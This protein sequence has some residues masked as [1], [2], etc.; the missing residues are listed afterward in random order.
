MPNTCENIR[1]EL[2]R[3]NVVLPV[4]GQGCIFF[5]TFIF[6]PPPFAS[7]FLK[8]FFSAELRKLMIFKGTLSKLY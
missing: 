7:A 5:V 4:A 3:I 8:V 6:S 2:V 1:E